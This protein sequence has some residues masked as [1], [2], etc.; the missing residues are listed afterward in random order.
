MAARLAMTPFG[1]RLDKDWIFWPVAGF[2][3]KSTSIQIDDCQVLMVFWGVSAQPLGSEREGTD[4]FYGTVWYRYRRSILHTKEMHKI[5]L[6]VVPWAV[7][8]TTPMFPEFWLMATSVNGFHGQRDLAVGLTFP[9]GH[10]FSFGFCI[11]KLFLNQKSCQ[12]WFI[13]PRC[14]SLCSPSNS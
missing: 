12:V 7:V 10:A 5:F 13:M 1:S 8:G 6:K 11:L 14:D 3:C 9:R 2:L 4:W